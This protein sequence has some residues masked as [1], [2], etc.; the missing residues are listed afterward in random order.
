MFKRTYFFI[1]VGL[2]MFVGETA[3]FAQGE[4]VFSMEAVLDGAE[5]GLGY[6]VF[7]AEPGTVLSGQVFV[8]NTGTA[9]GT[10]RLYAVDTATGN[11]GGISFRMRQD[12][13]ELAGTWIKPASDTVTLN[14]GTGAMVGFTV[15]VPDGV[16]AGQHIGGLV[17]ESQ[18][19]E[20]VVNEP[21]GENKAAFVVDVQTRSAMAVQV[22]ILGT[23]VSQIDVTGLRLGGHNDQQILYLQLRNSGN[24]MLKPTGTIKVLNSN[25]DTVQHLR[26]T[27]GAFLP[28]SDI[29][30]PIYIEN[31]AL[32]TGDYLGDLRLRYEN[33]SAP[34]AHQFDFTVSD[35]IN[36]QIFTPREG[37]A[38]PEIAISNTTNA[39]PIY[40]NPWII[41]IIIAMILVGIVGAMSWKKLPFNQVKQANPMDNASVPSAQPP[42]TPPPSKPPH[43]QTKNL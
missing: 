1:L 21:E 41:G 25:G 34:Q 14:P 23:A 38:A 35:D 10:A 5:D 20:V 26:F 24:Q 15:M 3:V 17:L 22:N 13:V 29:E 19:T 12:P 30:Y 36:V 11:T 18:G 33:G 6:F 2:L 43:L 28:D 7:E 9:V 39:M 40:R 27:L 4:P 32:G 8:K 37:L 31:T 42:K 16:R